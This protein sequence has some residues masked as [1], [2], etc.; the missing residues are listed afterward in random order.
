MICISISI[1]TKLK[2][3]DKQ[4]FNELRLAE[5][6]RTNWTKNHRTTANICIFLTLS[7]IVFNWPY[8]IADYFYTDQIDDENWYG[9]IEVIINMSQLLY[10][11]LNIF[12]FAYCSRIYRHNLYL[13]LTFAGRYLRRTVFC[14]RGF[15]QIHN[16]P[17]HSIPKKGNYIVIKC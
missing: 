6:S 3:L 12:F 8:A 17:K 1:I 16:N 13:F 14:R 7:Y 9:I 4:H 2:E 5:V 15:S 10:M 11:Q